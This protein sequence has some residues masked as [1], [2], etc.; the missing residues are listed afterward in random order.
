M[1]EPRLAFP[2]WSLI[3]AALA[4][5]ATLAAVWWIAG[6]IAGKPSWGEGG[7]W[8]AGVIAAAAV[9]TTLMTLPWIPK[10][11]ST[12][13]LVWMAGTGLRFVATA[14]VAFLLYS[15]PPSGWSEDLA[16]GAAPFLLAIGTG[17][18]LALLV[19]VAVIA[20]RVFRS[21]TA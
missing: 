2:T 3:G 8:G 5:S 9:V 14:G 10:P 21:T 11:A 16:K 17:F 6:A 7:L 12:A 1:D 4:G 20:R 18:L 13:G 19:E 15:A